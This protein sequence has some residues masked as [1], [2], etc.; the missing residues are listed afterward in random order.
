MSR[1]SLALSNLRGFVILIVVAFHSFLAYLGSQPATQP[2]F[3][4]PPYHW[5]AIPILDSARWFGFDLFCAFQY[6]YL[7]QFM[8]FLSGLFVWPSIQRKGGK[9]FLYDRF[10]RLGVPF[11]LGVYLLM[12]VAHYPVYRLSAIDPSWSAF[13][14]KWIALPFWPSGQLWFL[15]YL[16]ALNVAAVA[17]YW[18]LPRPVELLARISAKAGARP[19]RYFAGLVAV[20]ALVYVPL[21]AVF[22][23]WQWMQFGPF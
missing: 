5:K 16:L 19:S 21:A 2:A 1:S 7:M 13:W 8:F 22:K 3:D 14:A 11:L 6:V 4:S 10:L 17:I 18:L 20:S 9:T 23:P 12:P 15:W